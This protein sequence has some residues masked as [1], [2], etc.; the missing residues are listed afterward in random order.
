MRISGLI[1]YIYCSLKLLLFSFME[2]MLMYNKILPQ[3]QL[4]SKRLASLVS[5]L[6]NVEC[7]ALVHCKY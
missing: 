7:N 6:S 1:E 3:G 2:K 5:S 4:R